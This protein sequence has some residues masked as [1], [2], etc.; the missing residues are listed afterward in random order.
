MSTSAASTS[1]APP[2][3]TGFFRLRTCDISHLTAAWA[4]DL[5]AAARAAAEETVRDTISTHTPERI[6]TSVPVDMMSA[7]GAK[8]PEDIERAREHRYQDGYLAAVIVHSSL[9][10]NRV[11][12]LEH[13]SEQVATQNLHTDVDFTVD[14]DPV[15][16]CP[17]WCELDR[18]LVIVTD[19]SVGGRSVPWEDSVLTSQMESIVATCSGLNHVVFVDDDDPS[20]GTTAPWLWNP[21]GDPTHQDST[22][23]TPSVEQ[24]FR[25]VV[26][27]RAVLATWALSMA[28]RPSALDVDVDAYTTGRVPETGGAELAWVS[29]TSV[30]ILAHQRYNAFTLIVTSLSPTVERAFFWATRACALFANSAQPGAPLQVQLRLVRVTLNVM[31]ESTALVRR[32]T[33]HKASGSPVPIDL[34]VIKPVG[35][36][37]HLVQRRMD[38]NSDGR[39]L[40]LWSIQA[41]QDIRDSDTCTLRGGLKCCVFYTFPNF[42]T[43]RWDVAR[44]LAAFAAKRTY[45]RAPLLPSV[46]QHTLMRRLNIHPK[47][48]MD[49]RSFS[50]LLAYINPTLGCPLHVNIRAQQN[51]MET[52]V[53]FSPQNQL[54]RTDEPIPTGPPSSPSVVVPVGWRLPSYS[55][56]DID[57]A[58][59]NDRL[60]IRHAEQ[61]E[62]LV[63]GGS[64]ALLRFKAQ[65]HHTQPS[66]FWSSLQVDASMKVDKVLATTTTSSAPTTTSVS[67]SGD[68]R[69]WCSRPHPPSEVG[70]CAARMRRVREELT[71]C[72][73][74]STN[75]T[76]LFSTAHIPFISWSVL[77]GTAQ[78]S[79]RTAKRAEVERI[80]ALVTLP[81]APCRCGFAALD[82]AHHRKQQT[83]RFDQQTKAHTFYGGQGCVA[84]GV[85]RTTADVTS[86]SGMVYATASN[87]PVLE[88]SSYAALFSLFERSD[89]FQQ[90]HRN[91]NKVTD[92]ELKVFG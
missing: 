63:G 87:R 92:L 84:N 22:T 15:L 26:G 83:M 29:R 55:A 79:G 17:G 60:P 45:G 36:N 32:G 82:S 2:V 14:G 53:E 66:C 56:G 39:D 89:L 11:L 6:R 85:Q 34:V 44:S 75:G 41:T 61:I 74:M 68:A 12:V 28:Y 77:Y 13:S 1:V 88:K 35:S 37:N 48:L 65:T 30:G 72:A 3:S 8:T 24:P 67:G 76:P 19:S 78:G 31:D 42:A 91:S 90:W 18:V 9:P 16:H 50:G 7:F 73:S 62:H 69:W 20:L 33:N 23:Q 49:A 71:R 38:P 64:W 40:M 58:N 27:L 4:G 80:R 59:T 54:Q 57:N 51:V 52:P 46:K 81:R 86:N 10:N 21:C 25:M 5:P 43:D 47:W 70:G